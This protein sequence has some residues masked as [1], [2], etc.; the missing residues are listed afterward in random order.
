MSS[1]AILAHRSVMEGNVPFDIPDFRTE[2]ARA[3]YENDRLTPCWG[4]DGSAPNYPSC[5]H[6]DYHPT[7]EQL[8]LY[9]K[10]LGIE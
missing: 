7:E 9:R 1:V 6:P 4:T 8:A 2:E 3:Q 5:S 10:D